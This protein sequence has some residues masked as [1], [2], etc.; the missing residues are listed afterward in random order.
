M[1]ENTAD[2]KRL[3]RRER[4]LKARQR[5]LR[6]NIRNVAGTKAGR[7][8]LWEILQLC[9]LNASSY[10]ADVNVSLRYEGRRDVGL[11]II[12]M[13][14]AVS[15]HVHIEMMSE[16]KGREIQEREETDD[17]SDD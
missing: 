11:E 14:E 15:P 5:L 2:E 7:A 4:I 12:A 8:V 10:D 6:E 13:L 16:A 3:A 1:T 9:R 17:R